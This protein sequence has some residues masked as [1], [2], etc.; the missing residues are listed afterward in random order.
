MSAP[1]IGT[2]IRPVPKAGYCFEIIKVV[3]GD[4]EGEEQWWC[5]HYGCDENGQPFKDGR[6]DIHYLSGLKKVATGVWKD[7]WEFETPRWSCCPLYYRRLEV[8]CQ[9]MGLF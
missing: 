3:P 4:N 7:E 2:F 6:Q 1:T 5:K 9:Q 8:A